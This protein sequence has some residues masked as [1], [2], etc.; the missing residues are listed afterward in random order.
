MFHFVEKESQVLGHR[1][2]R[3]DSDCLR[4]SNLF[5]LLKDHQI[6]ILKLSINSCSP[7]LY[8]KLDALRLPYY[9]LGITVE[10]KSVFR[11][12][13][14]HNYINKD[15]EFREYIGKEQ[16]EFKEMVYEVFRDSPASYFINP[17]LSTVVD[18]ATQLRCLV[19]YINSLNNSVKP[20]YF[21]HLVLYKGQLAGFVCSYKQ[22]LGGG[23]TYGG[24][25][26]KFQNKGLYLDVVRFIQ[27]FGKELGQKWGTA[28]AQLQNTVVQKTFQKAGL[29]PSGYQLNI[30]INA[31]FGSLH[32]LKNQTS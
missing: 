7:E 28:Q 9:L 32:H 20:Y 4:L 23:A 22:G 12:H 27:N 18:E 6:D 2:A 16:Y 24:I 19:E 31:F 8:V 25:L 10:Y 29:S 3:G 1:V 21:T 13:E 30:H 15:I 11:Q 14:T 26:P 17:G 5:E